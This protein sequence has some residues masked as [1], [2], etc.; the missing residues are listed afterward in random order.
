MSV[1][2]VTKRTALA[3][4]FKLVLRTAAVLTFPDCEE[5]LATAL[6]SSHRSKPMVV[7][8][9][10]ATVRGA[11][12]FIHLMHLSSATAHVPILG[13]GEVSD[14]DAL[15]TD[16]LAELNEHLLIPLT[17]RD[18]S[19]AVK[20]YHHEVPTMSLKRSA[21]PPDAIAK[22]F[23]NAQLCKQV[24]AFRLKGLGLGDHA[25]VLDVRPGS[26]EYTRVEKLWRE[27]LRRNDRSGPVIANQ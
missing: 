12:S 27:P 2:L 10:I 5:L 14:Y 26:A 6:E 1:L 17:G 18:L 15:D 16:T 7:A 20:R 4:L 13:V 8:I 19:A 24:Q 21:A 9:D 11:K 23:T 25:Y 22:L 3:R